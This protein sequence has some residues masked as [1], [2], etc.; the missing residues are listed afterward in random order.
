MLNI[1]KQKSSTGGLEG[2][3]VTCM[4]RRGGLECRGSRIYVKHD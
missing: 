3:Y 4:D 2:E 1:A